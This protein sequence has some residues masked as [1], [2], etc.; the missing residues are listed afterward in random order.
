MSSSLVQATLSVVGHH[1]H[2]D[3]PPGQGAL[4]PANHPARKGI[5]SPHGPGADPWQDLGFSTNPMWVLPS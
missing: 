4:F 5:D 1:H 2:H 3:H